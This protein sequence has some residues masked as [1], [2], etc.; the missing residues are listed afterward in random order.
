MEGLLALIVSEVVAENPSNAF[1]RSDV[2]QIKGQLNSPGRVAVMG[3]KLQKRDYCPEPEPALGFE[4]ENAVDQVVVVLNGG[5]HVV[6]K[7]VGFG[8]HRS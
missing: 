3:A 4:I 6:V 1:A 5:G 2:H 8:L 7:R